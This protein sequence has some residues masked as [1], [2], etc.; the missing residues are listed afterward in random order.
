MSLLPLAVERARQTYSHSDDCIYTKMGEAS[1]MLCSCGKGKDLPSAF[2]E[3]MKLANAVGQKVVVTELTYRAVLSP[4][5]AHPEKLSE[6]KLDEKLC[7]AGCAKCGKGG[8][9]KK[10]ARC[11]KIEYCSRECQRLHWKAHKPNCV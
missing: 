3:S 7:V 1:R 8:K 6:P 11:H 10:C 9:N 2:V 5:F 4:L